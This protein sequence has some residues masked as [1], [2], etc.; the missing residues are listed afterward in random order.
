MMYVDVI[1]VIENCNLILSH[2]KSPCC[3]QGLS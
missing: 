3:M 1:A 2:K